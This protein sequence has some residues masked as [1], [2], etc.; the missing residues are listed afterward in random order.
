MR[1]ILTS[2]LTF[3]L[4]LSCILPLQAA[5]KKDKL[6]AN[7]VQLKNE[8]DLYQLFRTPDNRH[9]PYV[10]WWWNGGRVNKKEIYRQLDIM[11]AVGISGVEI[12]PISFPGDTDPVGHP[13]IE[14]FSD[15]WAEMVKIAVLACKERNMVCD[16]IVGSGWPYGGEFLPR[17]K[18]IQMLT[19]H[20]ID[21]DSQMTGS[22]FTIDREEILHQVNPAIMA[23]N[24]PEKEL[25]Y[26][27]LM[28]KQINEFTEGISIDEQVNNE[29][30]TI[31]VPSGKHVLY[32]FVKLTGY[33]SVI[34]GAPGA[35][36]PVVNHYNGKAVRKYLDKFSDKLDLKNPPLKGLVRAAFT[37]SF[38]LEGANWDFTMLQEFRERKENM[39]FIPIS[40]MLYAKSG[41][42][43]IRWTNPMVQNSQN[44]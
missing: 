25:M 10:R 23:Q 27:R 7:P 24:E 1:K 18:Q 30:I 40:P 19:V 39:T 36:G 14:T 13:A 34:E 31:Q 22:S 12:N 28:P 29:Q 8:K 42:W 15:E 3:C 16:M 44:R 37:D 5:E 26:L 2:L 6:P 32:C 33:M 9:Y 38:E 41:I 17:E 43:A 21:L 20:T 4:L 35:K 11:K